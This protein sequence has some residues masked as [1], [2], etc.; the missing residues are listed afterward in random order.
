MA[1]ALAT[2]DVKDFA[3][4]RYPDHF[5]ESLLG[6]AQLTRRSRIRPPT[7]LSVATVDRPLFG[8]AMLFTVEQAPGCSK[9][10]TF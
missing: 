6:Q 3:R 2:V 9:Q 1:G 4:Q 10:P 5:G 8:F 7:W